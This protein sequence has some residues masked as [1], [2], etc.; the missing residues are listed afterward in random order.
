MNLL[1]NKLNKIINELNDYI[2]CLNLRIEMVFFNIYK[3]IE[4]FSIKFI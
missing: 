3:I 2:F 4:I 1:D